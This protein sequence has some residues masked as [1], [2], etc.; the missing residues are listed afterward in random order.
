VPALDDSAPNLAHQYRR[1]L[2][3]FLGSSHRPRR[4]SP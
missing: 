2:R 3:A 1:R 4:A